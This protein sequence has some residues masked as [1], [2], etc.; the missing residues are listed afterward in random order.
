[1]HYM[2]VCLRQRLDDQM[3]Q[4]TSKRR[5]SNRFFNALLL[6]MGYLR[7]LAS[8][9]DVREINAKAFRLPTFSEDYLDEF[10]SPSEYESV[11]T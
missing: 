8:A 9:P 10:S 7:V 6:M 5:F 11:R 4:I 3:I 2:A 1:M